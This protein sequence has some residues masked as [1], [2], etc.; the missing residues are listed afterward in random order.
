MLV[1]HAN[2][3]KFASNLNICLCDSYNFSVF[4]GKYVKVL[5]IFGFLFRI[6][7]KI[8]IIEETLISF[9][10]VTFIYVN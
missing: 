6:I 4:V 7:T 2:C 1:T 10:W 9:N 8:I 5:I 3:T